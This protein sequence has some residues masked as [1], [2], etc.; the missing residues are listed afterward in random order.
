MNVTLDSFTLKS[1]RNECFLTGILTGQ[2]R[3]CVCWEEGLQP[4]LATKIGV[5]S[6]RPKDMKISS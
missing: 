4:T 6:R 1:L 2:D 5:S 3:L